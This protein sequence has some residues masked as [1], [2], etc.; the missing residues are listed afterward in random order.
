MLAVGKPRLPLSSGVV[1]VD[2]EGSREVGYSLFFSFI[3][4]R[5]DNGQRPV[6]VAFLGTITYTPFFSMAGGYPGF[7]VCI[8]GGGVGLWGPTGYDCRSLSFK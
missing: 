2:Y 5:V 3:Y 4:S 7:R 1:D 6:C 8:G